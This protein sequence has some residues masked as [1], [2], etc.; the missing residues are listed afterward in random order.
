MITFEIGGENSGEEVM[1]PANPIIMQ[2]F[3]CWATQ[4]MPDMISWRV[5]SILIE[6]YAKGDVG[7]LF[8][9]MSQ[10]SRDEH[11]SLCII[12]KSMFDFIGINVE[13]LN[14]VKAGHHD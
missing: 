7:A 14:W 2:K 1:V 3:S 9:K 11:Y 8:G 10:L 12:F 4:Y 6:K 13:Y 5:L